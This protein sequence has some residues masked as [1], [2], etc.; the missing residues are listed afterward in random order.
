MTVYVSL[1]VQ[2]A[3]PFKGARVALARAGDRENNLVARVPAP[4]RAQRGWHV[5]GDAHFQAPPSRARVQVSDNVKKRARHAPRFF[6]FPALCGLLVVRGS[7]PF[8]HDGRLSR[9]HLGSILSPDRT[10][11]LQENRGSV[12]FHAVH[13]SLE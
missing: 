1:V 3:D 8:L 10:R 6:R 2:Y 12:Q 4:V 9:S 11:A 7:L 13:G 5:P